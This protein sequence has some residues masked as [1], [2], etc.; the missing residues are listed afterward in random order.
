[1][2]EFLNSL[3]S[4]PVNVF[5]LIIG[6]LG[7]IVAVI[8]YRLSRRTKKLS[9]AIRTTTLIEG[10]GER[11]S[12]LSVLYD[13]KRVENLSISRLCI[14]NS[15]TETINCQDIAKANPLKIIPRSGEK[16]L[17]VK[18]LSTNNPSSLFTALLAVDGS[19]SFITFDYLNKDQGAILQ[20]VHTGTSSND[21][22]LLGDIKGANQINKWNLSKNVQSIKL[23]NR[24]F[25][26]NLSMLSF[27]TA[28]AS[29]FFGMIIN[30]MSYYLSSRFAGP[31]LLF[32]FIGAF[33]AT[34]L[35]ISLFILSMIVIFQ[36]HIPFTFEFLE[37]DPLQDKFKNF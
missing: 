30:M 9:W 32:W 29:L 27:F 35:L 31:E 13:E 14:W 21:L 15:G 37:V 26:I 34:L 11:L 19:H 1:M 24:K 25:S 4:E 28:L 12:K 23:L 5:S 10:Y 20:L 33:L 3:L 17:D 2:E 18:I 16:I 6:V 22:L 8:T 7:I 36:E